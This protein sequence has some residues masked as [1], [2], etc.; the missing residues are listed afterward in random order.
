MLREVILSNLLDST[1]NIPEI[2]EIE[3]DEVEN[4]R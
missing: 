2:R 1:V 4:T 3:I